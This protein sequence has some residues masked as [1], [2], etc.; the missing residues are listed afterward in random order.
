MIELKSRFSSEVL[1]QRWDDY[2]SPARFAGSDETMDLVYVSK[3]AGSNVTL[4]RRARSAREPF[5]C[6]FRGKI[7]QTESG[8]EI[9]G[10][11]T[12]SIFDYSLVAIVMGLLFYIRGSIIERGESVDTINIIIA[13]SLVAA[14]LL[15]VNYRPTKRKYV[16]FISRITDGE[17]DLFI[18]KKDKGDSEVN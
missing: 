5:S 14:F 1:K 16:E 2:T 11:F 6:V 12:K 17:T 15:L 4:V 7:R 18:S 8:S 9:K 3:R 10:I 13:F